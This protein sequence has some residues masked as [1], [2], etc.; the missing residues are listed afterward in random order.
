MGK[1]KIKVK[2]PWIAYPGST[3]QQNYGEDISHGYLVWDIKDRNDFHVKFHEL[4]NPSPYV[5]VNWLG[6]VE[7]TIKFVRSN[8]PLKSRFRICSKVQLSQK[9][10][11]DLSSRLLNDLQ[12]LDITFKSEHEIDR[13]VIS[14]DIAT[15][16]K[17][18]LRNPDVII[19]LFNKYHCDKTISASEW[20]NV[21]DFV[22]K[23]VA[24][25]NSQEI[26]R[27]T[28]WS[29][30]HLKFDNTFVYGENNVINFNKLNGIV[31]I[32]GPNRS[33][34]SSIVGTI[35]YALFNGTDR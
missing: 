25:I 9:E 27:N 23:Y 20:Q 2:K 4:L 6:D 21:Y 26:I 14:T 17:E 1:V 3:I 5:T 11:I 19:K 34:K 10:T 31:G 16:I 15:M 24:N 8:F 35:M 30:K 33:G 12:A 13:N 32:F 29:L 28:K 7:S 22:K 18:D